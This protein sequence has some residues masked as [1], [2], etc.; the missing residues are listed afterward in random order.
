MSKKKKVERETT[1]VPRWRTIMEPGL[2]SWSPKILTPSLWPLESRPF[3]VLPAPFLWAFSMV[4]GNRF[5]KETESLG[6][7]WMGAKS[8]LKKEEEEVEKRE[9]P[10]NAPT[11]FKLMAVTLKKIWKEEKEWING[12]DEG[13]FREKRE[14]IQTLSLER[15]PPQACRT[16]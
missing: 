6:G 2:A 4:K 15:Q 8:P 13:G 16:V 10:L 5:G 11:R 9:R 1:L 3:L 7:A 12:R 14:R